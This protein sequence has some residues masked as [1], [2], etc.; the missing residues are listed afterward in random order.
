MKNRKLKYFF[1]IFSALLL[2]IMI[3]MSRNAGISCDDVLHYD[4]SLA[5]YN[6]FA[7]HGEDKSALETPVTNLR[8]YGQ[9]YDNI[10]TVLAR[11]FSID[12]V[13]SF[14]HLMSAVAG[15]LTIFITA[16]FGIWLSGYGTGI[17]I[18]I[19][20][21]ASPTFIGHSLNNLKDIPFALSYIAAIFLAL[22]LLISDK[23]LYWY[24]IV[25]LV[26]SIAFSISIRAPGI[27]LICYL[28]FFF[29]VIWLNR[30]ITEGRYDLKLDGLR[31]IILILIS[32]SA[33]IIGIIF[34]P[35]ALQSP[36]KNVLESY[37][38]MAHFPDTFRQIFEGRNEWSDF[39]PWYYL[40]KSMAIT[41]PV[42][43]IAGTGC[44]FLFLKKIHQS[45]TDLIYSLI[46]FSVLFPMFF[47]IIQKSN[48]YSSWRQFLFLYPPVILIAATGLHYLIS[49]SGKNSYKWGIFTV[50]ILLLVHPVRFIIRNHPYEY[51]YYNQ[52]VGGL[53]GAYG[54]YET[55]YYYVSQTAASEWLIEYL[56]EKGIDSASVGAT[57]PVKWSFRNNPGIRTFYFRHEERSQYD[58]DYAIVAN[59]Y[60][61]PFQLKN[62]I[63]PPENVIHTIYADDIPIGIVL[64]RKSKEDYYGYRALEEGRSS[65][66]ITHYETALKFN[67]KDEMIFYNFARALNNEGFYRK[68]DSALMRGLEINPFCEPIL[69]YLGNIAKTRNNSGTAIEYYERLLSYNRK[70]FQ[71]YVELSGLY[72]R[73]DLQKARRLLRECLK[74]NP[75][76]RPAIIALGDTY[77]KSNPD[78]ADKIYKMADTI[79]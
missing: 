23:K 11:W 34:W 68:A 1:L 32:A 16:I 22:R 9:S 73:D 49:Y 60:I 4:H 55:D 20:F 78:I 33:F 27:L 35:Y 42:V 61:H 70:Y 10:V 53:K 41:I 3:L 15:W 56:K 29:F 54:K 38:V 52:L 26:L 67:E 44:F 7:T 79:K 43:V 6:Y 14:R 47:V 69:M 40:P 12:D 37:R 74:L 13:Y 71:A 65:E 76:Y 21:A 72:M 45:G 57:Y 17:L 48:L 51:I 77:R 5:V 2:F 19:L 8:Y 30:Y 59:R 36:I 28:L 64:E 50:L 24:E 39:M 31:L 66:A 75:G 46:L 62:K 63:W 18:I 58:W 25:L